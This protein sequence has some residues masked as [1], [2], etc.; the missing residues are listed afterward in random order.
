MSADHNADN[1]TAMMRLIRRA[2]KAKRFALVFADCNSFELQDQLTQELRNRCR[3]Q[4]ITMTTLSFWNRSVTNLLDE[5]PK[6]LRA[7]VGDKLPEN[8]AIQ[9]TDVELSILID[10]DERFPAV[11]QTLNLGRE[12]YRNELPCPI[13]FWL[14][15][16]VL[17]KLALVA[18]DFWSVRDGTFTFQSGEVSD[19]AA[20][21]E[22]LI[23]ETKNI[24]EW[25]E[26]T[27]RIPILERLTNRRLQ[28]GEELKPEL[29][30]D[31][32]LQL[33]ESYRFVGKTYTALE[34]A[35]KALA[36][37]DGDNE[38]TS[39]ALNILGLCQTDAGNY[40]AAIQYFEDYLQRRTD[41]PEAQ[42]IGYNHLGFAYHKQGQPEKAIECYE[43]ALQLNREKGLRKAEG[44]VLGNL[45][46]V[47]REQ[48]RYE[49]A[50]LVHQ[51]ALEISRELGDLQA[52]TKDIGNIGLVYHATKDFERA[53][54]YYNEALSLCQQ[55]GNRHDELNQVLNLGDVWRDGHNRPA[56]KE[57]YVWALKIADEIGN[58]ALTLRIVERLVDLHRSDRLNDTNE[59]E[60][61]LDNLL[62]RIEKARVA[63]NRLAGIETMLERCKQTELGHRK[64]EWLPKLERMLSNLNQQKDVS[65]NRF[66]YC[67]LQK[68]IAHEL[69]WQ[70]RE[71]EYQ[72]ELN[73]WE[74]NHQICIWL[75]PGVVELD[76]KGCPILNAGKAYNFLIKVGTK[77]FEY[78]WL[79]A[80]PLSL[81]LN[82]GKLT[83]SLREGFKISAE[84]SVSPNKKVLNKPSLLSN[85]NAVDDQTYTSSEQDDQA[86][87]QL[88][89]PVLQQAAKSEAPTQPKIMV[90]YDHQTFHFEMSG[91]ELMF[92]QS[93]TNPFWS[94]RFNDTLIISCQ[95]ERAGKKSA[96]LKTVCKSRAFG[97]QQIA[98][99]FHV[100]AGT[101]KM[102]GKVLLVDDDSAIRQL[103]RIILQNSQYEVEE[104]EDGFVAIEK[105]YTFRPH[106]IM[107]DLMMPKITGFQVCRL[108]KDDPYFH[109]VPVII[110]TSLD[111]KEALQRSRLSGADHFVMKPIRF[112]AFLE[113]IG[114][115]VQDYEK[116]RK[117]T[118]RIPE[119]LEYPSK[120]RILHLL[121]SHL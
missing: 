7:E 39:A 98:F 59:C 106:V 114:K 43:K 12:R 115:C 78:A 66:V 101:P 35:E 109:L 113:L 93:E 17:M 117:L 61:W 110:L 33:A 14:P 2:V 119:Q 65:L 100:V 56:A 3:K 58:E 116:S 95:P 71:A 76:E 83:D 60:R 20:N 21:L 6:M 67:K 54:R 55:T 24:T 23:N 57:V 26:H 5:L 15:E 11:L 103:L 121:N 51:Q 28:E 36:L 73:E 102:K 16:Y 10:Q 13:I 79:M 120:T 9:V 25:R 92:T 48:Q 111:N 86:E 19:V 53:I 118:P 32:E 69:D 27:A 46:L 85:G 94:A 4:D 8:L 112:A 44:D 62:T 41:K 34:H 1:L 38:K 30:A 90:D 49:D 99:D 91:E 40:E 70:E 105:V 31:L 88:P 68:D 22:Q 84:Q 108:L 77:P 74:E 89:T 81:S 107:L 104:A 87:T 18:P 82:Y 63:A 75:E 64:T 97:E 45:G 72:K 47:Y 42:A 52:M 80:K 37:S 96:L 29:L 50:L